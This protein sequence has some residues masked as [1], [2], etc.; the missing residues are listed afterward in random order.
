M[1]NVPKNGNSKFASGFI[2]CID[3]YRT[4]KDFKVGWRE[5]MPHHGVQQKKRAIDL[6][7]DREK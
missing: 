4:P 5:L 1:T 7:N 2:R 3:K 6:Y